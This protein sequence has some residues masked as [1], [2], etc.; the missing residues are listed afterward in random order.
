MHQNTSYGVEEAWKLVDIVII[1]VSLSQIHLLAPL[2][3]LC[4]H[5]IYILRAHHLTWLKANKHR[6]Q[7]ENL[8]T[9]IVQYHLTCWETD[10]RLL[11]LFCSNV[12]TAANRPYPLIAMDSSLLVE[13]MV[14]MIAQNFCMK[15]FS[16]LLCNS[17]FSATRVATFTAVRRQVWQDVFKLNIPKKKKNV[18]I[19]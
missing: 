2:N 13:S 6:T 9:R 1:P 8:K 14:L 5:Q 4:I 16:L 11:L 10:Y 17:M 19:E 7:L 18:Y 12:Q 15:Y 3:Q